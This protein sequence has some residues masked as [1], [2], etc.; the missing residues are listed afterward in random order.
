VQEGKHDHA[1]SLLIDTLIFFSSSYKQVGE[2]PSDF[3]FEINKT[4]GF[5]DVTLTRSLRGEQIEVLVAMPTLDQDEEDDSSSSS[6]GYT[7]SCS[8]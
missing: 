8:D 5:A 2:I 3:P 4:D 7:S 6:D 1:L